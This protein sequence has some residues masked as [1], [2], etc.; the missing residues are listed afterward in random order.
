MS[1]KM[2][3]IAMQM[4]ILCPIVTKILNFLDILVFECLSL[5]KWFVDNQMQ[6]NPD[7]F[8]SISPDKKIHSALTDIKIADVSIP[9][10]EK[11]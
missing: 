6:A 11:I 2:T 10:E 8:Q 5:L 4:T 9:C 7:K 1:K 3:Y